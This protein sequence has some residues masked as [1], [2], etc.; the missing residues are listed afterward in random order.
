MPQGAP[1]CEHATTM[2]MLLNKQLLFSSWQDDIP[3]GSHHREVAIS[4][5]NYKL[6][7]GDVGLGIVGASM[8][9]QP[10]VCYNSCTLNF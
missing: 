9:V 6:K 5:S 8:E 4:I 3:H 10:Q 7:H 2:I 1:R